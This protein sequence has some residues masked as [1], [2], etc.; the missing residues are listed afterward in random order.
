LNAINE[1]A[2]SNCM[3][4]PQ[5]PETDMNAAH[6]EKVSTLRAELTTDEIYAPPHA[7]VR[8]HRERLE[9]WHWSIFIGLSGA[10]GP[11]IGGVYLLPSFG[12]V[13]LIGTLPALLG[14]LLFAY[15][16]HTKPQT[17]IDALAISGAVRGM[18]A[19]LA[20]SAPF[21][22]WGLIIERSLS[23]GFSMLAFAAFIGLHSAFAGAVIA[24]T[25]GW[26]AARLPDKDADDA[27]RE[28]MERST[29]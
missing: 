8:T 19:T 1:R 18:L 17:R 7:D 21:A 28:N 3:S 10:I 11:L 25:Y 2:I 23:A 15:A 26:I 4:N 22:I 14:A 24:A 27:E 20:L 9:W 12:L 5:Q 6:A 13:Y 16:Q 29:S